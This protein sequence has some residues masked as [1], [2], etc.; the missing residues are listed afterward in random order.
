MYA[1][2]VLRKRARTR[3][4]SPDDLNRTRGRVF[5]SQF[6]ELQFE[7]VQNLLR[8]LAS[9]LD[10]IDDRRVREPLHE[11]VDCLV[12]LDLLVRIAGFPA[13]AL[14]TQ[15]LGRRLDAERSVERDL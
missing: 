6:F 13:A 11:I 9:G 10:V 14:L 5:P 8:R 4:R 1:H 12:D 3:S 2:P 15:T 7:Q